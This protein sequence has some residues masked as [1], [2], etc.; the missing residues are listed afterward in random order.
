MILKVGDTILG[1]WQKDFN[2][3]VANVPVMEKPGTALDL[4][5]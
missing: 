1:R 4:H 2:P 5:Y 3:F